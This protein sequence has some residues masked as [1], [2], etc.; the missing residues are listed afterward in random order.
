MKH[1]IQSSLL[2]VITVGALLVSSVAATAATGSYK[3]RVS[4][5][6]DAI[7]DIANYKGSVVVRGD[8][9]DAV[10]IQARITIDERYART[11]PQKAGQL[12]A[13]I[14]RTL[15][16]TSDGSRI[17]VNEVSKH[18][19]KRYATID[20]EILVPSDSAVTVHSTLGDVLVSGVAGEV[21]A[22]SDKG[23]VTPM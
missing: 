1:S 15:P 16:I 13:E 21:N 6:G 4:V 18:K 2:R 8:D 3:A 23:D 22:T 5:D 7:V 9:V 19:H 17:A 20:Y 11:D 14:K 12:I 10:T